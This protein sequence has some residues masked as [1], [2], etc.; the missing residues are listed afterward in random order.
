[1]NE[2]QVALDW[3]KVTPM[4]DIFSSNNRIFAVQI[5]TN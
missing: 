4:A 3:V 1:M 2:G 5:K